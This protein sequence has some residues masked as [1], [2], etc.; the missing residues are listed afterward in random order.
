MAGLWGVA[1][2]GSNVVTAYP[3]VEFTSDGGNP[4]FRAYDNGPFV[5][6]G[7][8]TGFVY[9]S[10][11]TLKMQL[12]SNGQFLM[13]VINHILAQPIHH[14]QFVLKVRSFKVITMMLQFGSIAGGPGVTYDI[15]WDNLKYNDAYTAPSCEGEMTYTY[16][17]KIV[18]D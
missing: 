5:D 14:L 8:P 2:N 12:L 9:D 3:I 1:V 6:L 7:L 18:L 16:E 13:S 17:L 10:W 4:R 11:V 15:Y